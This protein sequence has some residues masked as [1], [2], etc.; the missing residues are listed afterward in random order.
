MLLNGTDAGIIDKSQSN[1]ILTLSGDAKSSTTQSKYLSSSMY[2]DGNGD[3]VLTDVMTTNGDFTVEM[4][5]RFDGSLANPANQSPTF[6]V[7]GTTTFMLYCSIGTNTMQMIGNSS[8]L[9]SGSTTISA[10]T[11]Y[12]VAFARQGSTGRLY[13]NGN[14]EGS[15]TSFSTDLNARA[16]IGSEEG[17]SYPL[18]GYISDLRVTKGL[19]R[20]TA[21]DEAAN[22]PTAAL[23]G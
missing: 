10:D 14:L 20:Y 5:I 6:F 13:V 11:W 21:A 18:K 17:A 9:I 4:W 1:K 15:T 22:I 12:H 19:A 2:F 7:W 16:V 23:Q 3:N 8:G